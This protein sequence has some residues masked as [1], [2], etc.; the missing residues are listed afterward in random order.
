LAVY[1]STQE[2]NMKLTL[3]PDAE[4]IIQEQLQTHR[5]SDPEAVVLAALKNFAATPPDEFEIGEMQSLLEEG[6]ESI[7]REGTLD[8]EEAFQARRARRMGG[9]K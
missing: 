6:E 1:N 9:S 2:F 4:Q 5:F 7:K 8:A 3:S